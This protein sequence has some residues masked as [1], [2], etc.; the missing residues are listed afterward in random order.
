MK[1]SGCV[2]GS[3]RNLLTFCVKLGRRENILCEIQFVKSNIKNHMTQMSNGQIVLFG[4]DVGL[5]HNVQIMQA[6]IT[7]ISDTDNLMGT[8]EE[9]YKNIMI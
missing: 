1:D 9:L 3:E 4:L 8:A 6:G 2:F 5:G 7:A